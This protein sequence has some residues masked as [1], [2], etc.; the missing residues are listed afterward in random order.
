MIVNIPAQWAP[1]DMIV[2]SFVMSGPPAAKIQLTGLIAAHLY[3]FLT[4][5]YPE[6]GGGRNFIRTPAFVKSWFARG[7]P[8]VASRAY[9]TAFTPADRVASGA[10]TTGA[11]V[12]NVLPE[13]WKS[14]GSGQ[15]LGGD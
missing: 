14:R 15:R 8:G 13:S 6:F 11:S 7:E 12:G 10:R 1:V 9:G 2:I 3:D 5:L 4:R